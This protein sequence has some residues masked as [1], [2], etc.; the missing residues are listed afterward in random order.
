M[1]KLTFL[2]I[3]ITI[4][5]SLGVHSIALADVTSYT[6]GFNV[7]NLDTSKIANIVISFYNQSG[8]L[9]TALED[10]VQPTAN[11]TYYPLGVA[12][13]FNGSVVI[14]SD[15]QVAA[16][17]NVLGNNG[18]FG[19]SYVGSSGGSPTVQLPLVMKDNYGIDTWFNVQN[20]SGT[21]ASIKVDYNPGDCSEELT[22]QPFAAATFNQATN[23]CLPNGYVGG[24]TIDGGGASIV[25]TTMQV[26]SSRKGLTP[27]LL[28]YNGFSGTVTRP[29]VPTFNSGWYNSR[30]SI[31]I[32][33]TSMN[34]TTVTVTYTPSTGFPGK[35][36]TETK[37]IRGGTTEIFGFPLMPSTCYT[38]GGSGGSAAFVGSAAVTTNTANAPLTAI[39]NMVTNG[40][41]NA[42]AY[43]VPDPALATSTV[44]LPLIM[45]R[46]YNIFTGI[47]I[48][49]VGN[50][51][52]NISCTFSNTS[53]T[54][55]ANN[56]QPGESLTDVQLNKIRNGYVGSGICKATGGDAKIVAVVNEL[57]QNVPLSNDAL[58]VYE[59]INY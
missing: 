32:Q 15:V 31:N 54:V 35:V 28:A 12:A 16:I 34:D 3:I 27:N 2:S 8:N 19:A 51:A 25:A 53:Y 41:A 42:A 39:V 45:D 9:V 29:I 18:V 57:Q 44:S 22:I 38:S 52:T 24:A 33:N 20:T 6:S 11:N 56:V 40:S 17:A 10:T 59:G 55:S 48:A 1:K 47:A 7:Q 5:I 13:G 4:L 50:Q 14:S 58:L 43:G 37:L 30:S 49:N 46:N 26:T 36:C 21:A 23:T